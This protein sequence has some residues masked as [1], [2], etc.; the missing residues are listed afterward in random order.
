VSSNALNNEYGDQIEEGHP[1]DTPISQ[2]PGQQQG[3]YIA[4]DFREP[5]ELRG[6]DDCRWW[7]FDSHQEGLSE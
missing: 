1:S 3:R 7:C 2:W 4:A 6:Q 5:T